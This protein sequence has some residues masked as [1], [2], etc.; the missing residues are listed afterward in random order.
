MPLN[1]CN[2]V[3]GVIVNLESSVGQKIVKPCLANPI[4]W[5]TITTLRYW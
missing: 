5:K 3:V 1:A 2:M 4:K